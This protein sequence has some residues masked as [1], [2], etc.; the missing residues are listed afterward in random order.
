MFDELKKTK[1]F[2]TTYF[3]DHKYKMNTR[4]TK[5]ENVLHD[6]VGYIFASDGSCFKESESSVHD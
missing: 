3:L 5:I 1:V 2:F 4:L 6:A